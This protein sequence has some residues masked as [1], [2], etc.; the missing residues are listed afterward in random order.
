MRVYHH[1]SREPAA[2]DRGRAFGAACAGA[3]AV[4]V[5]SYRR[6]LGAAGVTVADMR[7]CGTAVAGSLGD[8]WPHFVEELEGMAVGAGQDVR[9]LLAV[10]ARTEL[11]AGSGRSE[12]SVIGRLWGSEVSLVQT[13]DWHPDFAPA[14]VLWTVHGP[15]GTWFTTVTEAG[16]LAKLGLNSHG[17]ACAL[18][19]LTCSADGGIGGVPIHLLLRLVLE[20]AGDASEAIELLCG[21]GTS[22]SSA[23]TVAY[24]SGGEAEL[25]AVELSPGGGVAVRPDDDGWLVHTNHF[26]SPPARGVDREPEAGPGSMLRLAH[27]EAML[28]AGVAPREALASHAPAEEPVCRH[29]EFDR[30]AV[31]ED[32]LAT[33]LTTQI[34]PAGPAFSLAPGPPCTVAFEPVA[35][36]VTAPAEPD[37]R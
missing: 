1:V 30:D 6:L 2:G 22:A 14:R 16:I 19:Y 34:N 29:I 36:P 7:A 35:L 15:E 25:V 32:Q 27:L 18:N 28:R 33:L 20:R 37:R 24:A 26:L 4:T 13:W 21:A 31:W 23:V 9:E 5:G 12:C 11:L 8:R 10:N 17:V 3:I